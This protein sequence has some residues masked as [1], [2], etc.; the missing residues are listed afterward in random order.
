MTYSEKFTERRNHRRYQVQDGAFASLTSPS[1]AK[2]GLICDIS[3]AG[4]AFRYVADKNN[5]KD[6]CTHLATCLQCPSVT[7]S[8]MAKLLEGRSVP[9]LYEII[10]ICVDFYGLT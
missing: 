9:M 10:V 6:S 8:R 3:K 5:V 1:E 7:G 4:L 2:L